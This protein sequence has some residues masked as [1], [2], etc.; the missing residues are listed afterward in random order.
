[1]NAAIRIR[2]KRSNGMTEVMLLMPHPMETGL[3]KG[4]DGRL[5]PAHFIT[6]LQVHVEGRMV[7]S[8]RLSHAVSQDPLIGFR[9]K[10]GNVGQTVTVAWVDNT[11]QARSDSAAIS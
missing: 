4:A 3:R 1:M 8:A 2:A 9:F 7:M 6:D 10:G 11:G 5:V